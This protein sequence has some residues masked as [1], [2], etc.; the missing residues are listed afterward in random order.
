MAQ[1]GW[2]STVNKLQLEVRNG[3]LSKMGV[4]WMMRSRRVSL[5]MALYDVELK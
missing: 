4:I 1:N 3:F 5:F 2:Y